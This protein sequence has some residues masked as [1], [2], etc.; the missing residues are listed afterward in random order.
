MAIRP[1]TRA[2]ALLKP[3]C[4][5]HA[6]RIDRAHHRRRQRRDAGAHADGN[7]HCG[8]KTIEPIVDALRARSACTGQSRR[9]PARNRLRAAASRPWR[10]AKCPIRRDPK[11]IER[12]HGYQ[13]R[14]GRRC[15]PVFNFDQKERQQ[16]DQSTEARVQKQRQEVQPDE[17]PRAEHRQRHQCPLPQFA[18]VGQEGADQSDCCNRCR[19]DPSGVRRRLRR[20]GQCPYHRTQSGRCQRRSCHV[21]RCGLA[22]APLPRHISKRD[23]P[24]PP[25]RER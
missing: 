14:S 6:V 23:I 5:T 11:P 3:G 22:V 13:G 7:Q 18:L 1:A 2:T 20:L 21:E 25:P 12:R 8:R 15:R 4:Q 9:R 24:R 19:P 10:A 17:H 16:H